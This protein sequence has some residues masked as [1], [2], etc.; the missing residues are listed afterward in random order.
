M[1]VIPD[2]PYLPDLA[3]SDLPVSPIERKT[4]RPPF[5]TLK[6]VKA[7]AQVVLNT[8]SEHDFQGAFI[9]AE[10]LETVHTQKGTASRVIVASRP[11][12][13]F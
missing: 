5:D 1:T 13:S 6:L 7:E 3:H 9:M 2:P 4:E 11:K 12:V 8:L 10:A